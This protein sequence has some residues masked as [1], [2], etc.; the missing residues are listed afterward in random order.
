M[1]INQ[2]PRIGGLK[3]RCPE[4]R[5]LQTEPVDSLGL[6]ALSAGFQWISMPCRVNS[7]DLIDIPQREH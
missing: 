1:R 4:C 6:A 7:A 5:W 3:K 2:P